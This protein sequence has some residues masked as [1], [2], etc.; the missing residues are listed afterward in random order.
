M[1]NKSSRAVLIFL[2]IVIIYF[3]FLNPTVKVS[4][5][6]ALDKIDGLSTYRCRLEENSVTARDGSSTSSIIVSESTVIRK[7]YQS[8]TTDYVAQG[9]GPLSR[10]S[11][12]YE[13][14]QGQNIA[15]HV[16]TEST[17]L[18]FNGVQP[19]QGEPWYLQN[20][21]LLTEKEAG[22]EKADGATIKV[23]DIVVDG[24][25]FARMYMTS[26]EGTEANLKTF[27]QTFGEVK[28]KAYVKKSGGQLVLVHLDLTPNVLAMEKSMQEG[29]WIHPMDTEEA[30]TK[31]EAIIEI[32][33]INEH[34]QIAIPKQAL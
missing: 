10:V 22:E 1:L 7:P 13:Q 6:D 28:G 8:V 26:E 33:D 23:F 29:K 18:W 25:M 34:E 32:L 3:F 20:L 30:H 14:E 16:L 11:T 5:K 24:T 12:R 15:F 17:G 31:L 4:V 2:L 9:N 19:K 21:R 27:K